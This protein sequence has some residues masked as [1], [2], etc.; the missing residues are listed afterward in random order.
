MNARK[1]LTELLETLASAVSDA[2]NGCINVHDPVALD[3]TVRGTNWPMPKALRVSGSAYGPG[4]ID[5]VIDTSAGFSGEELHQA[6]LRTIY[7]EFHHV[8]RWDGPGYGQTLG[9]AL[10]SEGL[11]QHFVHEMMTC[12]AEPWEN[13]I[14]GAELLEAQSLAAQEFDAKQYD[15]SK[16]FFGSGKLSRWTGYTVGFDMVAKY[17]AEHSDTTALHSATTPASEFARFLR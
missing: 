2:Q 12:P 10:V 1:Q 6:M 13:A 4:R 8:L 11:A 7:H 16:W 9:E 3:L 15:H 14:D 5:I 17:L